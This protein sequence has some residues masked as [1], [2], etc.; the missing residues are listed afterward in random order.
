MIVDLGCGE[1]H[2]GDMNIDVLSGSGRTVCNL[3]FE[4]I[5]LED[6]IADKVVSYDFIEHVPFYIYLSKT[7]EKYSPMEF[8]FAEV[9]RILKPKG[10]FFI[11]VPA[12]PF[13]CAF[14]DP[15]HMSVW[16]KDTASYL[17]RTGEFELIS[18]KQ[19]DPYLEIIYRKK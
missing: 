3:G 18:N 16:T 6:N 11:W 17:V 12:F 4:R 13:S 14:Q 8:L 5:P 19:K 2:R 7:G 1:D 10:T 15:S 9:A